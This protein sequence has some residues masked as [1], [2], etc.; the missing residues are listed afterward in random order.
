M[1]PGIFGLKADRS[2]QL[3]VSF[4]KSHGLL[5]VKVGGYSENTP[6]EHVEDKCSNLQKLW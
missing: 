2:L 6:C 3:G 4:L 5:V 1:P